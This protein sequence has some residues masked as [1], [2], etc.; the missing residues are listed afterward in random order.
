MDTANLFRGIAVVIDDEIGK[1]DANINNLILQIKKKNMPYLTYKELPD[2]SI[3]DNFEGI[4][5]LLLDWKLQAGTLDEFVTE[6]VTA[7]DTIRQFG[8]DENI[9][10]LKK[11]RE[12]CFIPVFIFTNENK[13]NIIQV[14]KDNDLFQEGKPNYIFV[15]RKNDLTGHTKL[16]KK[17][18]DWIRKTPSIYVLAAWEKVYRSSKTKLFHDF[19]NLSPSWPNILWKSFADDGVNMSLELGEVITRNL[20]TR[21]NPFSFDEK[22]LKK[23]R[24]TPPDKNEVRK[25]LEGERFIKAEGLHKDFIATGDIFKMSGG[26]FLLNI[27]PDCDCIPDRSIAEGGADD[28]K[29]YLLQGSKITVAKEKKAFRKKYGN[30]EEADNQSIIFNIIDG[31]TYDFR[32]KDLI[33]KNWSEI[34]DRRIGRLLPPYITRIQQRYALYLQRQGLPRIPEIAV[35]DD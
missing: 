4:S 10:F 19:Y 28:V 11:L 32:Y 14:L 17:I 3:I 20:Y 22:I 29:L 2:D 5:F 34:K 1:D 35:L 30:F 15:E 9:A 8:I 16:F 33:I 18:D 25:V 6:G 12:S 26:K 31:R 7:P 21:M 27:R 13:E 24:G 23:H